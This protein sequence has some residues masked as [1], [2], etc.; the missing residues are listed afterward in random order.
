LAPIENSVKIVDMNQAASHVAARR[1]EAFEQPALANYMGAS[2]G[3]SS[4][5][6]KAEYQA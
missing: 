4:P 6:S 1:P 3:I 5:L 2:G